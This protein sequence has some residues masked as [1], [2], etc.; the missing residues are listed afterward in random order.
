MAIAGIGIITMHQLAL[1]PSGEC[2]VKLPL[3]QTSLALVALEIQKF[4]DYLHQQLQRQGSE[5]SQHRQSSIQQLSN[6]HT[7]D[8]FTFIVCQGS[9]SNFN[10]QGWDRI[11][12]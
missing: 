8:V 12:I 10:K 3:E 1:D 5:Y 4:D 7:E 2:V 6:L 9:I 11:L